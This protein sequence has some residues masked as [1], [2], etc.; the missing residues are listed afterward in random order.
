MQ[1]IP[2][3]GLVKKSPTVCFVVRTHR[4]GNLLMTWVGEVFSFEIKENFSIRNARQFHI[5]LSVPLA[6]GRADQKS[7]FGLY[8]SVGR[9]VH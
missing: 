7:C 2:V 1:L 8:G 5:P 4:E 3:L 6:T 9:A